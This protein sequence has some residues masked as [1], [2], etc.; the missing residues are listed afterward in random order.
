M[1]SASQNLVVAFAVAGLLALA[2]LVGFLVV[3]SYG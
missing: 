3:K 1:R 2:V